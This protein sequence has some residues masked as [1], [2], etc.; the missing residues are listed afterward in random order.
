[1]TAPT[2]P[3]PPAAAVR[4]RR[5]AGGLALLGFSAA[6]VV[7]ALVDPSGGDGGQAALATATDQPAAMTAGALALVVCAVL[8]PPAVAAI[9]RQARDRGAALANAG[10]VF[11]VLGA[12]AHMAIATVGLLWLALPGGDP[13]EMAAFVDR[14]DERP[15]ITAIVL[16]L[17]LSFGV[18]VGLLAWAAW[19][20][21][22]VGWWGP[23]LVTAAVA[24]H[25]VLPETSPVVEF[26]GITAIAAVFGWLGVRVL[27]LPDRAW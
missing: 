3:A 5:P 22:L 17:V 12:A 13:A 11:A 26:A 10:A 4:A 8:T 16:P 9:L 6:L 15:E 25:A 18:G 24:A 14:V 21:G 20:A 1:M 7:N 19:R 27:R 23:A 2:R